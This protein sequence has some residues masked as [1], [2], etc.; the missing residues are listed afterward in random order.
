MNRAQSAT[1]PD[2]IIGELREAINARDDFLAIATHELRNPLTP[3]L[4]GV[5][6]IR[7]AVESNDRSENYA[8]TR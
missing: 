2:E 5:Q 3:I 7:T 1:G 6:L 4:L 8:G